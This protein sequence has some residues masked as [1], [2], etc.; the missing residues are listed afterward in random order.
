MKI[1]ELRTMTVNELDSTIHSLKEE[2]F[3]LRMKH[4]TQQGIPNPIKL[5]F[6]KKEIARALT[7]KNE[8][9]IKGNSNK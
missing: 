3:S 6:L 1:E 8:K 4:N 7:I 5:R 9:A 2:L